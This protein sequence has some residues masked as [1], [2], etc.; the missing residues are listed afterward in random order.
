MRVPLSG[1]KRKDGRWM[2]VVTLTDIRGVKSRKYFYSD[3][4]REVQKKAQAFI[5]K[6]GRTAKDEILLSTLIELAFEARWNTARPKTIDFYQRTCKLIKDNLGDI[7]IRKIDPPMVHRWLYKMSTLTKTNGGLKYSGRSI[8]MMRNT[9]AVLLGFARELGFVDFN[10][11]KDIRLP[12]PATPKPRRAISQGEYE[13][14]LGKETNA[15]YRRFFRLIAEA[16]LRPSEAIALNRQ[17]VFYSHDRYWI[18]IGIAKTDAGTGREV[19][20]PSDLGFELSSL[21]DGLLLKSDEGTELNQSNIRRAWVQNCKDAK[22]EP[23]AIYELRKLC[24][25]R[26]I[27][28]GLPPDVVKTM[29]GHT[30]IKL[31]MNVYNRVGR[32]RI[33]EAVS[34]V[35][36]VSE[37]VNPLEGGEK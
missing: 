4:Q 26:W 8:Q 17:N 3:S 25:S 24:L 30:D 29:A 32:D 5:A 10:A 21:P 15:A 27:A 14:V 18:R 36:S 33:S 35:K 13:A 11:A 34:A 20:I 9:L 2:I 16:G 31:T 12:R 19:P 6:N 7:E 1:T 28:Q 37:Y 23:V 22:I